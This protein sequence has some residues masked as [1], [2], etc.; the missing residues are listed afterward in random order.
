MD[1]L[2]LFT[3]RIATSLLDLMGLECRYLLSSRTFLV[4][5]TTCI[6]DHLLWEGKGS[7]TLGEFSMAFFAPHH[8][9][10]TPCSIFILIYIP[11]YL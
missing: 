11:H 4:A 7:G 9:S 10:I 5:T 6:K 3:G 2:K 8:L 1:R